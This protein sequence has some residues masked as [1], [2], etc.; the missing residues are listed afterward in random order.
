M[1]LFSGT[2]SFCFCRFGFTVAISSYALL[3]NPNAV[4]VVTQRRETGKATKIDFLELNG[5]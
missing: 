5:A 1:D 3:T 4:T 2:D